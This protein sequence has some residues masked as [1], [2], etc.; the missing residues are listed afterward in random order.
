MTA[1]RAWPVEDSRPTFLGID[2]RATES[3]YVLREDVM[4]PSDTNVHC[5]WVDGDAKRPWICCRTCGARTNKAVRRLK[6]RCKGKG[7]MH[8]VKQLDAGYE[9]DKGNPKY[10]MLVVDPKERGGMQKTVDEAFSNPVSNEDERDKVLRAAYTM[11]K[12]HVHRRGLTL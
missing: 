7:N 10:R 3:H 4:A 2:I 9:F 12:N 1:D 11:C 8:H 6:G 5:L